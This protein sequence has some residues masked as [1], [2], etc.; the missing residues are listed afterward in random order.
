MINT[1][2]EKEIREKIAEIEKIFS[3][4]K[5]TIE[6]YEDDAVV[7]ILKWVLGNNIKIESD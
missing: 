3:D 2:T 6:I 5:E 1:R 7:N 4:S